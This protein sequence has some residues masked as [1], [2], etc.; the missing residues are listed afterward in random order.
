MSLLKRIEYTIV[1]QF[2]CFSFFLSMTGYAFPLTPLFLTGTIKLYFFAFLIF[3]QE[4]KLPLFERFDHFMS[5]IKK[6]S[7]IPIYAVA[8][9]WL[10]FAFF[11]DLYAVSHY[12]TAIIISIAVFIITSGIFP[13]RKFEIPD[14]APREE[15][16]RKEENKEDK[17]PATDP[18][19]EALLKE[20]DL[21]V[22]EMQRLNQSIED[23]HISAQ[24]DRLEATTAKIIDHVVAH[25][26]KFSQIRKFMSYY[27]PTTIKLLNAY[28]RMGSAGI[29]GENI[30]DT[31]KKIED[32]L[33]TIIQS[34]EKQ[35]DSLFANEALDISSDIT[36][37]ENLL[38]QEGLG[39]TQL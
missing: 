37:M 21:A 29:S 8:A 1:S 39:S 26:E 2:Y 33:N 17:A 16:E 27:L 20:R 38:A 25:P 34:F 12:I 11:L 24:I 28:D 7:V 32:M 5:T 31:M 9:V 35:L 30:D 3:L 22:G 36:V 13:T 18:K 23:P 10:F 15:E 14:P 4:S 19:I 6:R